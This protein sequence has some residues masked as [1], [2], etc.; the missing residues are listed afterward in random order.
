MFILNWL[1]LLM[2]GVGV[3]TLAAVL[4]RRFRRARVPVSSAHLRGRAL[5]TMAEI[6]GLL[7]S[8][9]GREGVRVGR[10]QFPCRIATGHFACVGATGSGKTMLQRLLMQ[11]V[12]PEIGR[13]RG[14]RA[15]VYDAK[16][17][18]L[19]Q[20]AG[21]RLSCPIRIFHPLDSRAIA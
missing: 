2:G 12:L 11:S 17:D 15:L 7:A 13:G 9:A 1:W 4:L 19:S 8:H 6:E 14:C 21:M 20:L 16:Q 5:R 10:F 3:V 18:V